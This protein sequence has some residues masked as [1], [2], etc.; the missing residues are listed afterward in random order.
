MII[1]R[2]HTANFTTIGN[3]LFEDE[4]LAADEVGILAYLLSRPHDWEVRRSALSRRWGFGRDAIKRVITNL[5]RYGWCRAE[6][7]RLQN[8]TYYMI[9]EI[10]DEP[11]PTL[12]DE[13][14]RRAFSL[15]SSEAA[16]DEIDGISVPEDVPVTDAPPTPYPSLADPSPG[17]PYLAYK[18]IQNNDLPRMDSTQKIEREH[19]REKEKHALNL[20]EFKRRW[21]TAASD[22][23]AMIDAAWFEL[24]LQDGEDALSGIVP[25]LENLKRD[26]RSHVPAGWK[27]LRQRRWT[28][29]ASASAASPAPTAYPRDSIEAKSLAVVHDIAGA[30]DFFRKVHRRGG[31]TVNYPKPVG[32][33]LVAL[34]QAPLSAEWVVL[35]RQQAAAWEGM[36]REIVIV[37]VRKH[38][39]EGDR[40]PWPWPP[41]KDGT[42][43]TT[44]PPDTLMSDQDFADFKS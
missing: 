6:R 21:P 1:R 3:A 42:L 4:R 8:G 20:A 38:L 24:S 32:P 7:N 9:Y 26:K 43:S 18:D 16:S 35:N 34:A 17:N 40:A 29:L 10:R 2:R 36:L 12:T 31:G 25:F 30:G 39:K 5:V 33:K 23:Q 27:Y 15:V 14:V 11:G 13:Q 28:L 22:D 19:A 44:G 41:R 37:Q